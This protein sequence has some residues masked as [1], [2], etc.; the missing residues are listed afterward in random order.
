MAYDSTSDAR[1][2]ADGYRRG[3]GLV[4]SDLAAEVRADPLYVEARSAAGDLSLLGDE[5]LM[6]LFLILRDGV[7]KLASRNIIEFGSYKGGTAIFLAVALRRLAPEALVYALDTFG[8]MPDTDATLD[9]H[10]AGDFSDASIDAI[11]D[12]AALLGLSN[13]RLVQGLFEQT[14]PLISETFGLAHIDCDIISAVRYAQRAVWPQMTPGGYVVFDD[15]NTPSCL[16]ATQAVEEMI[17]DRR[18]LSEQAWPHHVF[19]A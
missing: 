11:R 15:S 8:G 7:T 10:C 1:C 13:L 12:R 19:R 9:M 18:I 5:R 2:V 4:H 17:M 6:N 14:F 3:W 16:G